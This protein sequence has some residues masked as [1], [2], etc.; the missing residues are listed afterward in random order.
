MLETLKTPSQTP[1]AA[2]DAENVWL[3]IFVIIFTLCERRHFFR[4]F[5]LMLGKRQSWSCAG[6]IG[7]S[8]L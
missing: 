1:L 5:F 2:A 7:D 3:L 4:L 8:E 6:E